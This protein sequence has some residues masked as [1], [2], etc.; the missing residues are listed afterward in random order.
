ME[1]EKKILT[2]LEALTTGVS[3]IN[4]RL[5]GMDQRFDKVEQRLDKIEQRLDKV[6]RRLDKIESDIEEIKEDAVITRNAANQL[7]DWAERVGEIQSVALY[8]R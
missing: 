2:M 1:N 7:L 3:E 4:V 6:E 8:D 5:D